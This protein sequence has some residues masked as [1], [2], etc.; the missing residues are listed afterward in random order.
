MGKGRGRRV[1]CQ[2]EPN[3][4]LPCCTVVEGCHAGGLGHLLQ[5]MREYNALRLIQGSKRFNTVQLRRRFTLP[6]LSYYLSLVVRVGEGR[7]KGGHYFPLFI[8]PFNLSDFRPKRG[9]GGGVLRRAGKISDS[10]LVNGV[11]AKTGIAWKEEK[12]RAHTAPYIVT[13]QLFYTGK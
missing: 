12:S 6:I 5:Y 13:S 1:F 8:H 4:P 9:G 2:I 10:I 3:F 7:K 11:K